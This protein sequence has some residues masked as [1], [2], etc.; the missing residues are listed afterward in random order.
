MPD[1]FKLTSSSTGA[2]NQL[3]IES[4]TEPQINA[5]D[6]AS[7]D[8]VIKAAKAG[9]DLKKE[10]DKLE[11]KFT[12]NVKNIQSRNLESLVLFTTLFSFLSISVQLYSRLKTYIKL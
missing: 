3:L 12:D 7:F 1:L 8:K 9:V 4:N 6:L 11:D 10:L 2:D 5:S